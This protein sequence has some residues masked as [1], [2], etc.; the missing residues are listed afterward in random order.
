MQQENTYPKN[1]LIL[2]FETPKS[3]I[4]WGLYRRR[5]SWGNWKQDMFLQR[6]PRG[7]VWQQIE[8]SLQSQSSRLIFVL[9]SQALKEQKI[10][11]P[12]MREACRFLSPP[13][14]MWWEWKS[15]KVTASVQSVVGDRNAF[16]V[17]SPSSTRLYEGNS[18]KWY[19]CSYMALVM[20]RAFN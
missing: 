16:N 18:I 10:I 8:I 2:V 13:S 14:V 15:L 4:K 5:T 11:L 19:T 7:L 3:L 20:Q 6:P 12:E 17:S 1:L 9:T